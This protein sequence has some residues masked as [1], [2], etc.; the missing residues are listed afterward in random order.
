MRA[1]VQI[2]VNALFFSVCV[3][4]TQQ[5][6]VQNHLGRSCRSKE[7]NKLHQ[8][9]KVEDCKLL[10]LKRKKPVLNVSE[11]LSEFKNCTLLDC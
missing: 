11:I 3:M 7:E 2:H 10:L 5:P 1:R 6:L 9:T 4:A 8:R